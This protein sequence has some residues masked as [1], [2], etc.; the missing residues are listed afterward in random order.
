MDQFV[1]LNLG[2]AK[3]H[4]RVASIY[5]IKTYGSTAE[6]HYGPARDYVAVSIEKNADELTKITDIL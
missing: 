3:M 1:T 5:A 6:I 2:E 4:I